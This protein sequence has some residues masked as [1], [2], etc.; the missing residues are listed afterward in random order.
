MT[1][2][3]PRKK[4]FW[5]NPPQT[6]QEIDSSKPFAEDVGFFFYPLNGEL[7]IAADAIG[8][9][10]KTNTDLED[11]FDS[12]AFNGSTSNVNLGDSSSI[13]FGIESFAVYADITP[14]GIAGANREMILAKDHSSGRQLAVEINPK[15]QAGTGDGGEGAIGISRFGSAIDQQYTAAGAL[16]NG[17]PA[18][19]LIGRSSATT[20]K[21]FVGTIDTSLAHVSA[22]NGAVNNTSTELY[23]GQRSYPGFEDYFKGEIRGA[24][25][26]N[27]AP[28]EELAQYLYE[29]P[30]G[31]LKPR[32][33]YWVLPAAAATV[34][35]IN[36][37]VLQDITINAAGEA[38][39]LGINTPTLSSAALDSTGIALIDGVS[40]NTLADTTLSSAG[41]ALVDGVYVVALSGISTASA[42]ATSVAG[43]CSNTLA[44]VTP[45]Y[46]GSATV[47]GIYGSSLDS[48]SI[49]SAGEVLNTGI[50]GITFDGITLVASEGAPVVGLS[51][52]ALGGISLSSA[53]V[54]LTDGA[55][56]NTLDDAGL[57]ASEGTPLIGLSSKVLSE[58][59]FSS[60]GLVAV[61]GV[62][63]TT[64][65][66]LSSSH[67]A[68]AP[69]DGIYSSIL[70]GIIS[71]NNGAALIGGTCGADLGNVVLS[72]TIGDVF[73]TFTIE[74]DID[75]TI[76][77]EL[78]NMICL[79]L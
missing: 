42:G 40:P 9:L 78:G 12:I 55:Y 21:C 69:I 5:Q 17:V 53:G 38:L 16:V 26:F 13:D 44:G 39:V 1:I 52:K 10:S 61:N 30:Y 36:T 27:V 8:D 32:R 66:E 15:G 64:F 45:S 49:S 22:D 72:A 7:V 11:R 41:E 31:L 68:V 18:S 73:F 14:G 58:V 6:L 48:I 19:I 75:L 4:E 62:C 50:Y 23:I 24:G 25:V 77:S 51:A 2:L 47:D 79:G 37:S 28:S 29:A 33:K 46:D 63:T 3:I 43:I 71:S 20:S 34:D 70:D 76:E 54:V 74:S 65:S 67:A 60:S 57:V 56:A 35:G 59:S